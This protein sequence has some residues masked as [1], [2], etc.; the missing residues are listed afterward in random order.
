MPKLS[1]IQILRACAA[2]A[3]ALVHLEPEWR[4]RGIV[5]EGWVRPFPFEAGVDV[6]F[7]ISGFVMVY[8]SAALFGRD[9]A[10]RIFLARRIARVV[11][12]Y[13]LTTAFVLAAIAFRPELI[14]SALATPGLVLASFLF[15]PWPRPDGLVQPVYTLGWT[16]NY[17]MFFYVLFAAALGLGL[18]RRAV[19][20]A[21]SAVLIGLIALGLAVPALPQPLGFW[22]SAMQI[23]FVLGMLLGTARLEGL[24]LPLPARL[25]LLA[26]GA[27]L[28]WL[29]GGDAVAR[30]G[31]NTA[32]LFALPAACLVA[33]C[34]LAAGRKTDRWQ[35][36]AHSLSPWPIRFGESLGDASYAIYLLHPFAI[37]AALRLVDGLGLGLALGGVGITAAGLAA[38]VAL[39]LVS[40]RLVE[41]PL[42]RLVRRRTEE[43]APAARRRGGAARADPG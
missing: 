15:I 17:E 39:A 7:V 5:P 27:G 16:L 12:L 22:T 13:W 14:R 35:A 21:L 28:F 19:V 29:V 4:L 37:R 42:T 36:P 33:G 23:E 40:Y 26:A 10:G 11:P 41:K 2:L 32:V 30:T 8:A 38:T 25:A 31:Q 9:G 34:G 3:I 43:R 1:A 18:A 24:T 6:F 20:G